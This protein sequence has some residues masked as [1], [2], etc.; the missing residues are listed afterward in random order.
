[1]CVCVRFLA[2]TKAA[3]DPSSLLARSAFLITESP[4]LELNGAKL[5]AVIMTSEI[6]PANTRKPR[7]C[8]RCSIIAARVNA[9][10]FFFLHAINNVFLFSVVVWS[11]HVLGFYL[12]I[13]CD[14]EQKF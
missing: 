9:C 6:L 2:P 1:M 5:I 13:F 14:I 3:E 12:I 7:G 8:A 4:H 10:F 11:L